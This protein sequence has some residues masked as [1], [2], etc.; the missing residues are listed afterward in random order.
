[1]PAPEGVRVDV[2]ALNQR[3]AALEQALKSNEAEL[4]RRAA[5]AADERKSRVAVV[6]TVLLGAVERGAPFATEL[7]AAKAVSPDANALAPLE[8]F[9]AS[10]LPSA[11]SLSRELSALIPIMLKGTDA[12]TKRDGGFLDKLQAN[13]ERLV[14]IRPVGEVSGTRPVDVIAR[15]EAKA[16]SADIAGAL[17]ELSKL[18]PQARAPAEAWI[19]KANARNAALAAARQFSSGALAAIGKP[20]T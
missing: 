15:V 2:D 18:S 4:A 3:I 7:A 20:N 16:G 10:G 13:A 9:A 5:S 19:K 14:R 8:S 11:P 6:A 12:E 1:V 17:D